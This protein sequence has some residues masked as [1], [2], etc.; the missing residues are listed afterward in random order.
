MQLRLMRFSGVFFAVRFVS[1]QQKTP[2]SFR[3]SNNNH[4]VLGIPYPLLLMFVFM[5]ALPISEM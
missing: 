5:I 1:G 4:F 3:A 2:V